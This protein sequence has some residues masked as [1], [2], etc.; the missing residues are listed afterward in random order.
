M[1][2]NLAGV[3]LEDKKATDSNR[4]SKLHRPLLPLMSDVDSVDGLIYDIL[5]GKTTTHPERE[6][7]PLSDMAILEYPYKVRNISLHSI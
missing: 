3:G 6:V 2:S 7:L 4:Y 1:F 5:E